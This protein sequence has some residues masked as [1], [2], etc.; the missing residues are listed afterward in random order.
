META[1]MIIQNSSFIT[2]EVSIKSE[3]KKL[4][5]TFR[6]CQRPTSY[7]K[8]PVDPHTNSLSFIG[9]ANT[10]QAGSKPFWMSNSKLSALF[11]GH[12]TILLIF[13]FTH[14]N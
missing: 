1:N 10:L 3:L 7:F 11:N 12:S 9:E 13:K 6:A 5:I 2:S 8:L 14:L 4:P